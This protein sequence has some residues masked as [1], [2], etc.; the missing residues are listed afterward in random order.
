MCEAMTA[1]SVA[2]ASKSAN[3]KIRK[4]ENLKN[5]TLIKSHESA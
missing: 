4:K 5:L 2:N 3:N 1:S